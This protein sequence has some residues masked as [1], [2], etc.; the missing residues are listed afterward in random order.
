MT[1]NIELLTETEAILFRLLVQYKS[2]QYSSITKCL[3]NIAE[4]AKN[5]EKSNATNVG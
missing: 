1:T 4:I 3:D 2:E 5:L